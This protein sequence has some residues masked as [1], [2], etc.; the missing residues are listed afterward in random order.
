MRG[1]DVR[2]PPRD[3][4]EATSTALPA[5]NL[6]GDSAI[7]ELLLPRRFPEAFSGKYWDEKT[8]LSP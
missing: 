6:D 7:I 8:F 2:P 5:F 4:T 1:D 3:P